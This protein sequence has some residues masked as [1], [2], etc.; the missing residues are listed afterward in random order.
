MSSPTPE[1][2]VRIARARAETA[3]L[4]GELTRYE[5]LVWRG[6]N[7]SERVPGMGCYADLRP[8]SQIVVRFNGTVLDG[9]PG[10]AIPCVLTAMADEFGGE[11][12]VGPCATIRDDSLGYGIVERLSHIGHRPFLC[13]ITES[14]RL[15]KMRMRRS[16]REQFTSPASLVIHFRSPRNR[17]T[18][19]SNATKAPTGR[20]VRKRGNE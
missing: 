18:Y 17:L 8:E 11:I 3:R 6:G 13:R 15:A 4:H 19:Y 5:L 7:I 1:T 12:P 2:E 9:T 14:S 16:W 20:P 10:E